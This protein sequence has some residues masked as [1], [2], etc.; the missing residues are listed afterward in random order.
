[1]RTS[2]GVQVRLARWVRQPDVSAF[3]S[4]FRSKRPALQRAGPSEE[5]GYTCLTFLRRAKFQQLNVRV[6][7]FVQTI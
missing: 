2:P 1:M 5:L 4:G 6:C 7:A 3:D